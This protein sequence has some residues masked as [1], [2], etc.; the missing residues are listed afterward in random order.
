MSLTNCPLK[1]KIL[2]EGENRKIKW[3]K[4]G[5]H[6]EGKWMLLTTGLLHTWTHRGFHNVHKITQARVSQ[7]PSPEKWMLMKSSVPNQECWKEEIRF[8]QHSN[9]VY[10]SLQH[11][12]FLYTF[13][14]QEFVR[15]L[16]FGLT[17]VESPIL[18][19]ETYLESSTLWIGVL[20]KTKRRKPFDRE[21]PFICFL[22]AYAIQPVPHILAGFLLSHNRLYPQTVG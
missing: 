4:G 22:N 2:S 10:I 5:R 7:S 16:S 11:L 18:I 8:L 9:T 14:W 13:L 20:L 19:A 12:K 17:E 6:R 3:A 1:L 15:K 21:H